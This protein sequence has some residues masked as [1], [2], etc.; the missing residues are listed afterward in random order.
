M[1]DKPQ[2]W[3]VV[4]YDV[5]SEPSKLKVRVWRE[6]KKLGALYPQSS[7]C[8]LPNNIENNKKLDKI[9]KIILDNGRFVKIS[10]NELEDKEH[11]KILN[12]YREERDKQ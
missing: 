9:S 7:L 5:P 12:M 11:V 3:I 6:F 10:A 1:I 4:L 2:S 8:I